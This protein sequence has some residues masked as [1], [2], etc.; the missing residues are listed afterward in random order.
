MPKIQFSALITDM[1]GKS[2]GSTFSKN[3]GGNYFR[4]T[5]SGGGQK[6]ARW[7]AQKSKFSQLAGMWRSLTDDQQEAWNAA[8]PLYPTTNAF[9]VSRLRSGYELYMSLNG[10]LQAA[11]QTMLSVPEAPR[12]L[13]S[14]GVIESGFPDL[15]QLN[16]TVCCG[17]YDLNNPGPVLEIVGP[18]FYTNWSQSDA[19]TLS[20]RFQFQPN[21]TNWL[22]T[23][24]AARLFEALDASNHGFYLDIIN[25]GGQS[26]Y[27]EYR[28]VNAGGAWRYVSDVMPGPVGNAFH[29]SIVNIASGPELAQLYLNGVLFPWTMTEVGTPADQMFSTDL[30]IGSKELEN[31]YHMVVSDF[32]WISNSISAEEAFQIANGYVLGYEEVVIPFYNLDSGA[33]ANMAG[34]VDPQF[35][36]IT[37]YTQNMQVLQPCLFGLVPQY[38]ITVLP[39][40][41]EGFLLNIYGT[42]PVSAG[43]QASVGKFKL[44]ATMPYTTEET[45]NVASQIAAIYGNIPVNAVINFKVQ[46]ID[47]YTG[48]AS[49]VQAVKPKKP[50]R[51]KAGAELPS[52]VS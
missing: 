32:R 23:T 45:Y 21:G 48:L 11:G 2:Q 7:A 42:G 38:E 33:F 9:G 8:V 44:L 20:L 41:G 19:A 15:F 50:K 39:A 26:C 14:T 47:S 18:N 35:F 37:G 28:I 5:R 34:T 6:T 30:Y 13:P 17:N 3:K 16:P 36:E 24:G 4:A 52:S 25:P 31:V 27:F 46:V 1:K 40:V 29:V 43:K 10:T 49:A 22:P 12:E 51:F